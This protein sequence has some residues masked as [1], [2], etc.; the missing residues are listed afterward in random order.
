M[1]TKRRGI[2]LWTMRGARSFSISLVPRTNHVFTRTL[3]EFKLLHFDL[4]TPSP[5]VILL[6]P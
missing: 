2:H 5:S 3:V 4:W 6:S 1:A